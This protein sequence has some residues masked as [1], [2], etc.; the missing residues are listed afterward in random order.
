METFVSD[1][2]VQLEEFCSG[3]YDKNILTPVIGGVDIGE[4]YVETVK[5]SLARVDGRFA[6]VDI[7]L[8]H[9]EMTLLRFEVFS[10]AWLHQ[11]GDRHAAAQSACTKTY[12]DRCNRADIWGALDPYNQAVARSGA[13]GHSSE[14][15][16]GRTYLAFLDSIRAMLFAEWKTQGVDPKVAVRAANRL[17]TD[18]AW[19]SGYTA[20][21]LMNTLCDR[22]DCETND[23]GQFC[24]IALIRDFYDESRA[25][26]KQFLTPS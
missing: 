15:P 7:E 4:T 22:L 14:T 19:S 16:S 11:I 13:L 6:D 21:A 26:I 23:E 18:V 24:L 3:F 9:T 5:S 25:A 20:G 17:A 12:L 10:L 8:L 2:E 1:R